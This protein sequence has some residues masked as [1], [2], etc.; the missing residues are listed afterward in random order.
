MC[1]PKVSE[2]VVARER[3]QPSC[4]PCP[5]TS[6][7]P[8]PLVN[9]A[10]QSSASPGHG[11]FLGPST[12]PPLMEWKVLCNPPPPNPEP[13]TNPPAVPPPPPPPLAANRV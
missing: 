7:P 6:E 12:T 8:W 13:P 2:A 4:P 10:A 1:A 9:A 11:D 3:P 5:P